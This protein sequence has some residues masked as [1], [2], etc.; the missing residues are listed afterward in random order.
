MAAS[1]RHLKSLSE[2]GLLPIVIAIARISVFL[3]NHH[4]EE[5]QMISNM[6]QVAF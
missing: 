6:Q 5:S 1:R 4:S 2:D 3:F